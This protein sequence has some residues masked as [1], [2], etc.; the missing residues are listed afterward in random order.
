[1]GAIGMDSSLIQ[2]GIVS[3]TTLWHQIACVVENRA[4]PWGQ[5]I[6]IGDR[7]LHYVFRQGTDPSLPTIVLDHS[8]AGID[9]YFVQ[10]WLD[11]KYS[12]FFY[13]R[14]GFGW[15]DISWGKRSSEQ[16]MEE[17][18]RLLAAATITGPYLLVGDSYGSYNMR[19]FANRFPDKVCGLV[20][21]DGLHE[22]AML[23]LPLLLGF[24]KGFIT[25]S[26]AIGSIGAMFGMVRLLGTIGLFELIKPELKS[27]SQDGLKAVK[28][29]FYRGKHWLTAAQEMAGLDRSGKQLAPVQSLGDLPVVTI[30]SKT[31]LPASRFTF[32]WPEKMA[33]KVRDR[34]QERLV[35]LSSRCEL[36]H[37]DQ[38][39]HFVW[40]D[41]PAV[42]EKAIDR[43]VEMGRPG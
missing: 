18:D 41:Q 36:I 7:Q 19:L 22:S 32:W 34:I 8:L 38:S 5:R 42:M 16:V 25:I 10:D 1:M 26:F 4:K 13:D 39:T 35:M 9:G 23:T 14:A 29:S 30:K 12:L 40:I 28:R 11:S 43:V 20:L 31:F 6:S 15:S 33:N 37:A 27:S 24:V 2:V 21:T 3:V 17:L